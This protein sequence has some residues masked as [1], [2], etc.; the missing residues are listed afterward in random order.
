MTQPDEEDQEG[1]SLID[2]LMLF[3]Y[4]HSNPCVSDCILTSCLPSR[5]TDK[6]S[7]TVPDEEGEEEDV[8]EL[9]LDEVLMLDQEPEPGIDLDDAQRPRLS[10]VRTLS[11]AV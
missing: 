7:M 10:R 1:L 6:Q 8:Q 5:R 11:L 4:A 3:I 2:F 9:A